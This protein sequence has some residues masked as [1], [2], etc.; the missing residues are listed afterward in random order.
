MD[1]EVYLRENL[2]RL[3]YK[4]YYL[5]N[6]A[7][8]EKV[9][10]HLQPAAQY[11]VSKGYDPHKSIK[12]D[13]PEVY[14][15][16]MRIAKEHVKHLSEVIQIVQAMLDASHA[17]SDNRAKIR[18]NYL[19]DIKKNHKRN[20]DGEYL[21]ERVMESIHT[22]QGIYSVYEKLT[23]IREEYEAITWVRKP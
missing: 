12:T 10:H 9:F 5:V 7:G 3:Q 13:D 21:Q 17:E 23:K 16:C 18:D 14:E 15:Q 6:D 2:I 11:C 4:G 8:E 22:G 19:E 1:K 20:W